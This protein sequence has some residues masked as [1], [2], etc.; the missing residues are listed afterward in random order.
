MD[1]AR[2]V[3]RWSMPG[4]TFLFS[5]AGLQLATS[6]YWAPS[7]N[8]LLRSGPLAAISPALVALVVASGVP[9]GFLIYQCYYFFYGNIFPFNIVNR[10]RGGEVLQSLPG[11]V[12]KALID[13]ANCPVDLMEMC[14]DSA[15]PWLQYPIIRLKPEFRSHRGRSLYRDRL[16]NNWETVR[17]LLHL[18]CLRNSSF[19]IRGE[20]TT[21]ADIYHGIGAS[22]I[23]VLLSVALHFAYNVVRK[24]GLW[25]QMPLR[26]FASIVLPYVLVYI[27]LVILESTR[28]H[29]LHSL[30]SFLRH[31]VRFFFINYQQTLLW[32][33]PNPTVEGA[34][35][36]KSAV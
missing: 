6:L 4:W 24:Q 14:E 3:V 36:A 16:Q 13:S 20:V 34:E 28:R 32:M 2:Q 8:T 5:A 1:A 25:L 21:L 31:S 23:A 15:I 7:L 27:V 11:D 22:R 18:L 35:I 10:D 33:A 19:E 29:T 17:F 12:T 30:Q 9:L 26:T